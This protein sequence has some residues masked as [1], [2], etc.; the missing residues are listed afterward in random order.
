MSTPNS[1]TPVA[2]QVLSC[3]D[4][5]LLV[6]LPN[7]AAVLAFTDHLTRHPLEGQLDLVPAARTILVT[8][9]HD[10]DLETLRRKL[11]ALPVVETAPP[12]SRTVT[13]DVVYDGEDLH[14]VAAL[15]GLTPDEVV[16]AH[17]ESTW[18]VAF[19]GFA[20]GFGYL[21][22]GDPRLAVP[23]LDSPRSA[24]P[25]GSVALA[26]DYTGVYPRS[27]PGGWQL[28]GYTDAVLWDADRDPP[29]L[30]EPGVR[31]QFREV[32]P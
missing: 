26:G 25:A 30:F 12:V 1:A 10:A 5:A 11:S 3:G 32:A 22:G 17:T 14:R 4:R 18:T 7:L 2:P 19:T 9:R 27:S 28:I 6:E 21:T 23:R 24:V 16:R 8:T 20:P 29:A 31:V 15:A 13:I